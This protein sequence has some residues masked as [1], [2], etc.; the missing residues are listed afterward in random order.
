MTRAFVFLRPPPAVE[1]DWLLGISALATA[2]INTY[3]RHH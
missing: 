2:T 3:A 1:L